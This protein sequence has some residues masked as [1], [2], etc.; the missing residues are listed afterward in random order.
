M[1]V[2]KQL[3]TFFKA[4]SLKLAWLGEELAVGLGDIWSDGSLFDEMASWHNDLE[5]FF[6]EQSHFKF[7]LRHNSLGCCNLFIP[8]N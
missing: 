2:F 8:Q 4:V 3:F 1:F 5:P 7:Y 6:I